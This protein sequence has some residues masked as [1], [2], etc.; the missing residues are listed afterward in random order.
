MS[1]NSVAPRRPA[2]TR[3][4]GHRFQS[5]PQTRVSEADERLEKLN[6]IVD[7]NHR[8]LESWLEERERDAQE[9][10]GRQRQR[11]TGAGPDNVQPANFIALAENITERKE[12]GLRESERRFRAIYQHA[13]VG[14]AEIGAD[15]Q[16]LMVNPALCC[17]LGY[18]ELELVKKTFA[19][20]THPEDRAREI[21]LLELM[22]SGES[23]F[24]E[25]EKRYLHGNGSVVWAIVTSWVFKPT[26]CS[27]CC[28]S[29]SQDITE[30]KRLEQEKL[31]LLDQERL[32]KADAES[33]KTELLETVE[34]ISDGFLVLDREW[35]CRYINEQGAR[36]LECRPED[37]I[38]K[39]IWTKLP[40]SVDR[41]TYDRCHKALKAQVPICEEVYFARWKRW[42]EGRI[43]PSADGLSIMFQDTTERR[44]SQQ[45]LRDTL[46]QLRALSARL[47]TAREEERK[48]VARDLHDQIGQILTA[49]KMDVDWVAKHIPQDQTEVRARLES[50]LNLV[51]DATQ[52]L[53]KI[54]TELRPGVLD[55]LGL[56][57]AIEWQANEFASR[58]SIQCQVSVPTEDL[59]LDANRSTAI[60][61][62][63]QE[64][65]TNVARHAEAKVVR[66]SLVHRNG[67]VL[68]VVQDDGKGILD[69]DLASSQ[70]SLG[71]L[72]M[73]E[74]AQACGGELHIWG[75]AGRGTTVA[76]DMSASEQ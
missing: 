53:R 36:Y 59:A 11:T 18:G 5:H 41:A 47:Q 14:I 24:Y 6:R 75:E 29:I 73:K 30:R 51:R 3:A 68:L 62:I 76:V 26:E 61:R 38:G 71:L 1:A 42:F 43:Y 72:G 57:A 22:Q 4:C 8:P 56:G 74:R 25:I 35:R 48:Q 13:R 45:E 65:L 40:E 67:R 49:T 37:L 64:A 23:D 27:S 12:A 16:F 63:L 50:T 20:I 10:I 32:A 2:K 19:E 46:E 55:D 52:S 54:C 9:Y 60:F 33:A 44:Q 28:I 7:V 69:S 17:M 21:A 70:G 39:D 15:G 31:L 66:V 34:R 58:T